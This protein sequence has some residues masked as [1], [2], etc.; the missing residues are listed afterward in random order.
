[1]ARPRRTEKARLSPAVIQSIRESLDDFDFKDCE[2]TISLKA[3]R[4]NAGFLRE[5]VAE[6]MGVTENTVYRWEN[7]SP[8]SKDFIRLCK[9]YRVDPA[10][11]RFGENKRMAE[12]LGR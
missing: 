2:T 11:I 4:I 1:M 12:L 3:A 8:Y 7:G 6:I 9:L 10:R 5:E